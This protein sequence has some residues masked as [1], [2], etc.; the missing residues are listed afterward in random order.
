MNRPKRLRWTSAAASHVGMVRRLN[1]DACLALPERGLW[2]VADGMGGH[3]AGEVASQT[4][5]DALGQLS[6][7][8]DWDAF[9]AAA[10]ASLRQANQQLREESV[11]RYHHRVI[12]STVVVLLAYEDQGACLWAGDSRLYRLRNGQL[13]QLTRDHSHVQDLVDQGLISAEQAVHHPLSNVITR[14]VGSE[15]TLNVDIRRFPLQAGDTF[16]LC[17]DGLYKA[18]SLMDIA[19]IL[20]DDVPQEVAQAL[21]HAA[22]VRN[23]DDNVTVVVVGVRDSDEGDLYDDAT[24]LMNTAF[25]R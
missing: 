15:E 5:I 18:V 12:G 13:Q 2:A 1:E 25:I 20:T 9:C 19:G 23:A 14:A 6:P 8:P 11:E 17:S 22:L 21:I 24:V 16:L 7:P 3:A 4:I 10:Q